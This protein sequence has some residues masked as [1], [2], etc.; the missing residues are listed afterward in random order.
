[1]NKIC[2]FVPKICSKNPCIWIQHLLTICR[3]VSVCQIILPV[4]D[5]YNGTCIL[6]KQLLMHCL[7][8]KRLHTFCLGEWK[9]GP[10]YGLLSNLVRFVTNTCAHTLIL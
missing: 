3:R 4:G 1:M 8:L 10:G 6:I 2:S 5:E 7:N 9:R